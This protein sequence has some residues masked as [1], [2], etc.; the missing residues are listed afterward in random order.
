MDCELP[1]TP[2]ISPSD[3]TRGV[4]EAMRSSGPTDA[5]KAVK[6]SADLLYTSNQ[7]RVRSRSYKVAEGGEELE[8]NGSWIGFGVGP[9]GADDRPGETVKRRRAKPGKTE[10]SPRGERWRSRK[11]PAVSRREILLCRLVGYA[12]QLSPSAL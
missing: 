11:G 10:I 12:Q 9:D 5:A 1:F 3:E 6:Y 2:D 8:E 4:G 7:G